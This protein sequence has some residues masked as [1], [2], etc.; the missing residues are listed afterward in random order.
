MAMDIGILEKKHMVSILLYLYA[1]GS[2]TRMDIYNDIANNDHMPD[3]FKVLED[4]GLLTQRIR[5]PGRAIVLE[6]TDKGTTV[7]SLLQQV[8]SMI[9]GDGSRLPE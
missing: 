1:R 6:L 9:S 8:D 2:A 3:K 7:A 5:I 4:A